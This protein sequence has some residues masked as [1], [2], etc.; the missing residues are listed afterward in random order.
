MTAPFGAQ[1]R[2]RLGNLIRHRVMNAP[3]SFRSFP[4]KSLRP[5]KYALQ[6]FLLFTIVFFTKA[7]KQ[8]LR[9]RLR[10]DGLKPLVKIRK[11]A[12]CAAVVPR[13]P[14]QL[15]GRFRPGRA[16]KPTFSVFVGCA[17]ANIATKSP[18]AMIWRNLIVGVI[19]DLILTEQRDGCQVDRNVEIRHFSLA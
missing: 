2:G 18:R 16:A 17:A 9:V 7:L 14:G 4:M 5:E 15:I 11:H 1:W 13:P 19:F 8:I 6:L 10:A 3:T 12:H